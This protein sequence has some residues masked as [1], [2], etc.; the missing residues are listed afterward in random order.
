[1]H[2]IYADAELTIDNCVHSNVTPKAVLTVAA[3]DRIEVMEML[4]V[5]HNRVP[6]VCTVASL[7]RV[8][9]WLTKVN[10]NV[11]ETCDSCGVQLCG[12]IV[13]QCGHLSCPECL[14]ASVGG[15]CH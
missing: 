2:A 14:I 3:Q 1:M 11:P 10:N 5:E 9:T 13:T 15:K 4:Q 6:S 8:E 7:E 12:L